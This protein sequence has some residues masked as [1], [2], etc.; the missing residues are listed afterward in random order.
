MADREI[1]IQINADISQA[2]GEVKKLE[3]EL[4]AKPF[5]LE[6]DADIQ[7]A[8]SDIESLK[9]VIQSVTRG[10]DGDIKLSVEG[11]DDLQRKLESIGSSLRN[12]TTSLNIQNVAPLKVLRKEYEQL[13]E[14]V[15]K[16]T[17][18]AQKNEDFLTGETGQGAIQAIQRSLGRDGFYKT[19]LNGEDL[20]QYNTKLSNILLNV[21]HLVEHAQDLREIKI[22]GG[23]SLFDV[24]DKLRDMDVGGFGKF[25]ES[26]LKGIEGL[27]DRMHE[28]EIDMTRAQTR[29]EGFKFNLD[30]NSIKQM[31][32]AIAGLKQSLTD[33][34]GEPL[35]IGLQ[36]GDVEKITAAF[37]KL[38][39]VLTNIHNLMSTFDIPK[40]ENVVDTATQTKTETT[41]KQHTTQRTIQRTNQ[42]TGTTVTTTTQDAVSEARTS[43]TG[44]GDAGSTVGSQISSGM[45]P[46]VQAIRGLLSAANEAANA[47][48]SIGSSISNITGNKS[49]EVLN[50]FR[51]LDRK[52]AEGTDTEYGFAFDS[53]TGRSSSLITGENRR[54][55]GSQVADSI[56]QLQGK[57]DS[58]I[59]THPDVDTAAFSL[60]EIKGLFSDY[61]DGIKKQLVK[62]NNEIAQLDV[63][64][65]VK[66]GINKDDL[67]EKANAER[68][69]A[70]LEYK[71]DN[72]DRFGLQ[73]I[74]PENYAEI[75]GNNIKQT[76]ESSIKESGSSIE[77]GSLE[78]LSNEL[79]TNIVSNIKSR[80]EG[81]EVFDTGLVSDELNN[82]L[83]DV[84]HSSLKNL[85]IDNANIV[86]TLRNNIGGLIDNL[87]PKNLNKVG[88][89]ALTKEEAS[90]MNQIGLRRAI[91][92]YG[93][94]GSEV[95]KVTNEKDL[96]TSM[97]ENQIKF[98]AVLDDSNLRSQLED[99]SKERTIKVNVEPTGDLSQ[100]KD[101]STANNKAGV[102]DVSA[103]ENLSAANERLA[104]T[105]NKAAKAETKLNES[106]ANTPNDNTID[107]QINK[108]EELVTSLNE[109]EKKQQEIN[110][111][112]Q[113]ASAGNMES[114]IQQM[115]E[116]AGQ[117]TQQMGELRASFDGTQF[118]GLQ[119][120]IQEID[121]KISNII[122]TLSSSFKGLQIPNAEGTT[123]QFDTI[124]K[125]IQALTEEDINKIGILAEKLKSF[126]GVNGEQIGGVFTSIGGITVQPDAAANITSLAEALIRLKDAISGFTG[127]NGLTEVISSLNELLSRSDQLQNLANIV[128]EPKEKID[129]VSK[130]TQKED[131]RVAQQIAE[132]EK[133][134]ELANQYADARKA[135]D[136]GAGTVSESKVSEYKAAMDAQLE[137]ISKMGM[138]SEKM[139][140]DSIKNVS[141]LDAKQIE[142]TETALANVYKYLNENSQTMQNVGLGAEFENLK[143]Q[144]DA[145]RDSVVA[146]K[147]DLA[148]VSGKNLKQTTD[149]LSKELGKVQSQ[150]KEE[151]KTRATRSKT[152]LKGTNLEGILEQ[153]KTVA[154]EN[155]S[156]TFQPLQDALAGLNEKIQETESLLKSMDLGNLSSDNITALTDQANA[157]KDSMLSIQDAQPIDADYKN[158]VL[159]TVDK[160]MEQNKLAVEQYKAQF[161]AIRE[162]IVN[163][164]TTGDLSSAI[165]NFSVLKENVISQ[166]SEEI[167]Q[168][169]ELGNAVNEY[170]EARE[171]MASAKSPQLGQIEEVSRLKDAY[172]QLAKALSQTENFDQ[173]K[174]DK[175]YTQPLEQSEQRIQ[176]IQEERRNLELL[177]EARKQ[178]RS[179]ASFV[180]KSEGY[181]YDDVTNKVRGVE[182]ALKDL[183]AAYTDVT[184][185]ATSDTSG[186]VDGI[187]AVSDAVRDGEDSVK[188][189]N[190]NVSSEI[191]STGIKGLIN[192]ASLA[193]QK[194][195][196]S[197]FQP[198][199]DQ[200]AKVNEEIEKSRSLLNSIDTKKFNDNDF[201]A[202]QQA[203]AA[204]NTE[205]NKMSD[206]A[207][208]PVN[209]SKKSSVLASFDQWLSRNT[210]VTAKYSNEIDTLR[211]NLKN[212]DN[213]MTFDNATAAINN[214]KAQLTEAGDIGQTFGTKLMKTF[215]NLGRYL[216]TYVSFYR[217]IGVFKDA[218]S[219]V[220]ELDT[221][222]KDIRMVSSESLKTI[223]DYQKQSFDMA[224]KIGS[225]ALD[226]QKSTAQWIRLGYDFNEAAEASS[227]SAWLTNVSE[228][229]S[230]DNA[231]T[232]L[233]SMKAAYD[234]LSFEDILDKLN[235][236]GDSFSSST[237]QLAS[238]LQN[239]AAVLQLQGNSIDQ[240]LALLTAGNDITQDMSKTSAGIRTISLRIAGTKEAKQEIADMGED[241]DDFVVKTQSKT[242]KIIRDY[243]AVAS[244]NYQGVSVL[245][246]NG[247]LRSTYDILLGISEVYKEIQEEDKKYG[248]NK[249][250]ALIEEL[251]GS[252][253]R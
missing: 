11:I 112:N 248:T 87:I 161:D 49:R 173:S 65:L 220:T 111:A 247:N 194:N 219:T 148:T 89:L 30:Q 174:F 182:S 238:G 75:L 90:Q 34:N 110:Q 201:K 164:Q 122:S 125:S 45:E 7:Q 216:M 121:T 9:K 28:L 52:Y 171:K 224:D 80:V 44:L 215:S 46:A 233:V 126:D 197:E 129:R 91:D 190:A 153:A 88:G 185:G 193:V 155:A 251:A 120:T 137:Y 198:M 207:L 118:S 162:T 107:R 58:F 144:A 159:S 227:A 15:K 156:T 16:F 184:S 147:D 206:K 143:T 2:E 113:D 114:S 83:N 38:E 59:H 232:A 186:I 244:N 20:T 218:I 172:E 40:I 4:K 8:K 191:E 245:D 106:V 55:A 77:I 146:I 97:Y 117:L 124:A 5:K 31:A 109:V 70:I 64:K 104:E 200:I 152:A 176:E 54:I 66:S 133:L 41:Q 19:I 14:S 27:R 21:G 103:T 98:V 175:V 178:L 140:K 163:A 241:I 42:A 43:L 249:S 181:N 211:N 127:E 192:R 81:K 6:V 217:I 94:N 47:I 128:K 141:V 222:L 158:N 63:E 166:T 136:K 243:T 204:L 160:F 108:N 229:D 187:K 86:D 150:V 183:R 142:A 209:E 102:V 226:L 85:N 51:E 60:D 189:F 69:K 29:E 92:S 82:T 73:N 10:K 237:D 50:T 56:N 234:D 214:F 139:Q 170:I 3:G 236:V 205:L 253:S 119:Q 235:G 252:N 231:T 35:Q 240:A 213:E 33:A 138:Y 225:N 26:Q 78:S 36:A 131:P 96:L 57:A 67:V 239:A 72:Y 24:V 132:Y 71:N 203:A 130:A 212:A 100:L 99:L 18:E 22:Q 17:K 95:Y 37:T 202:L 1:T 74:I 199:Q 250:Q 188:R 76:L 12:I 167:A 210:V 62:A 61:A 177:E 145:L 84:I 169:D 39:T 32:N 79:L 228:F 116:L 13:G 48:S 221:A 165:G 196:G 246:D 53:K 101:A 68:A 154:A 123:T 208:Q 135:F 151:V 179:G 180:D 115:T 242:D 168:Y 105:A 25:T 93:L 230:I 134:N 23:N 223:T 157:L 149:N 195:S